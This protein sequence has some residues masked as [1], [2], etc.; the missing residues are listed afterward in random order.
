MGFQP[1]VT[2]VLLYINDAPY[3]LPGS[4][5]QEFLRQENNF[6]W[7]NSRLKISLPGMFQ[8]SPEGLAAWHFVH[9]WLWCHTNLRSWDIHKMHGMTFLTFLT[10]INRCYIISN[11]STPPCVIYV[12][13]SY[14]HQHTSKHFNNPH[15]PILP[16]S[17]RISCHLRHGLGRRRWSQGRPRDLVPSHRPRRPD[18]RALPGAVAAAL[19]V[20]ARAARAAPGRQ[21]GR[22]PGRFD[23]GHGGNWGR[24]LE[25]SEFEYCLEWIGFL[26]AWEFCSFIHNCSY[27]FKFSFSVLKPCEDYNFNLLYVLFS[28]EQLNENIFQ[29]STG[30]FHL[31]PACTRFS[32]RAPTNWASKW[33]HFIISWATIGSSDYNSCWHFEWFCRTKWL[34]PQMIV[35]F[36]MEHIG[37]QAFPIIPVSFRSTTDCYSRCIDFTEELRVRF[38]CFPNYLDGS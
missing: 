7:R 28:Q 9:V 20:A 2:L 5:L 21:R 14:I 6:T 31:W 30:N 27:L 16:V 4:D 35:S 3:C 15:L 26:G 10:P 17:C 8:I 38:W 1:L 34:L 24:T 18:L 36:W 22:Q 33:Q 19:R 11:L 37:A 23:G 29:E 13:Y 32:K 12:T 25:R